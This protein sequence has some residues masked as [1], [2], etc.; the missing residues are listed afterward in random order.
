MREKAVLITG[1]HG[2]IGKAICA[3]FLSKGWFVI[4]TDLSSVTPD[5]VSAYVPSDLQAVARDAEARRELHS[6]VLAALG[7]R[8]MAA[9]VNNA[10]TQR[11]APVDILS[12]DDWQITLDIN[13]TAPFMLIKLFLAQLRQ[14]Q[15]CIINI[16]SVHAQATKREFA[17][18]ATSKAALH[19]LTRALAVD[20]GPTV[21]AICLAPAAIATSMLVSGFDG[22]Q[23]KLAELASAHPVGRIGH[24]DEV[25]EAALYLSSPEA[26]FASGSAFY[27]DGGILSRL[28]DPA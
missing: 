3:R 12:A 2:E 10:A 22:R 14:T 24:P 8:V 5:H 21:R 6:Q 4:G 23:D 16:G 27:L 1:A 11:L 13:V 9:L 15:G 19:G 17:A 20:L 25:A 18:Y 26:T 7:T 28:Y